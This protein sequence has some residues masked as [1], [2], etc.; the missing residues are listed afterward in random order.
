LSQN[1]RK[2]KRNIARMK[3]I[4]ASVPRMRAP[5]AP[6][7]RAVGDGVRVLVTVNVPLPPPKMVVTKVPEDNTDATGEFDV[8]ASVPL[9]SCVEGVGDVVASVPDAWV[10]VA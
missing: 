7:R 5:V 2:R 3:M 10:V 1:H 9:V 8:V 4:V 6:F